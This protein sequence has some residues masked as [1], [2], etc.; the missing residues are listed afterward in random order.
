M[1]NLWP[2]SPWG[3]KTHP[4][5]PSWTFQNDLQYGLP[6]SWISFSLRYHCHILSS[7]LNHK[8]YKN[9]RL[10]I[11]E[12]YKLLI[13]FRSSNHIVE[14]DPS[15][16]LERRH[17]TSTSELKLPHR[18][19][20]KLCRISYEHEPLSRS[21]SFRVNCAMVL[22]DFQPSSR[23]SSYLDRS[24]IALTSTNRCKLAN[25]CW[26]VLNCRYCVQI[27]SFEHT[28]LLMC[29]DAHDL[30]LLPRRQ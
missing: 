28:V 22:P 25:P 10:I 14:Y 26:H 30:H 4:Y 16:L 23:K 5:L 11:M 8:C 24:S 2:F 3:R 17:T 18:Y 7:N 6:W 12:I 27:H 15:L 9:I 1:H 29:H 13:S 21:S 20:H 19:I